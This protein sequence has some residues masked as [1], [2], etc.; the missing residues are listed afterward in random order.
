VP[1]ACQRAAGS[2]RRAAAGA[3]VGTAAPGPA[4]WLLPI[5]RALAMLALAEL[6][7]AIAR[8]QRAR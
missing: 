4:R 2:P 5:P 6:G 3:A 7:K 1:D 8:R